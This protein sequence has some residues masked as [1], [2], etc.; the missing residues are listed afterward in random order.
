MNTVLILMS[1][2]HEWANL[3]YSKYKTIELRKTA[4]KERGPFEVYLYDTSSHHVTGIMEVSH[5]QEIPYVTDELCSRA[6]L[7]REAVE[8]YKN[9]GNGKLYAWHID[10][11]SFYDNDWITVADALND[12]KATRPPQSWQYIKR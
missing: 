5:V 11:A 6:C 4:P 3:I 12:T 10:S 1:I 8:A 7:D 9:Q 2:H